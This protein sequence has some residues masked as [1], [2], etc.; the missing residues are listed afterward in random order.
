MFIGF[1]YIMITKVKST[2]V[3]DLKEQAIINNNY[4]EPEIT[5]NKTHEFIISFSSGL[6]FG[7]GLMISG[8]L[9]VTKIKGFLTINE[10]WDPSL[11]FVM[12]SALAINFITFQY[13]LKKAGK[14][15]MGA[16]LTF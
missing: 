12:A 15:K 4:P 11:G 13:A 8:M 16:D 2:P 1:V 10:N 14:P 9:R 5:P 3:S 6:L 7:L